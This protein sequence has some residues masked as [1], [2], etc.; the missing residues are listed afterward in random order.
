MLS[1]R[2]P[3]KPIVAR[4]TLRLVRALAVCAGVPVLLTAC[5]SSGSPATTRSTTPRPSRTAGSQ[6]DTVKAAKVPGYGTA[7]VTASGAAL[8]LLSSDPK[9]SSSCTGTCAK[10]WPPLTS[11]STPSA[12]AGAKSSLLS[13]FKRSDGRTQVLYG[14]HA[15]YTHPGGSASTLAGTAADG[16]VWYLVSPSGKAITSTS[17][18]GY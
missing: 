9:N 16:G 13:T 17:G 10:Q 8:Y 15:L 12:G 11:D 5:G 7:L 6:A 14:G 3:K 4:A 2:P 18:S 1:A